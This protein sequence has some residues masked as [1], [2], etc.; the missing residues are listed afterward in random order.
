MADLDI[1]YLRRP[2]FT[3][4]EEERLQPQQ[5][6]AV[7]FRLFSRFGFEEGVAGHI[8]ARDPSTRTASG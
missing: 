2:T 7:G 1:S 3:S 5:R 8:T 6:L 4:V